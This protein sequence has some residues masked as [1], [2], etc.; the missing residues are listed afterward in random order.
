MK[1]LSVGANMA[2]QIAAHEAAAARFQF[3][4][5][6]EANASKNDSEILKY[7]RPELLNRIAEL[8]LANRG[9]SPEYGVRELRRTVE[10]YVQ[11]PLSNLIL[12]GKLN[13]HNEWSVVLEDQE[14]VIIH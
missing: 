5:K 3:I 11:M 1:N 12:S 9:Y 10:K 8:F 7:F 14:I 13:E 4:E 2:W 6:D